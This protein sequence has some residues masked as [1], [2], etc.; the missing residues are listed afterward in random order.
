MSTYYTIRTEVKMHDGWHCVDPLILCFKRD[1]S[2]PEYRLSTTYWSGSRSY[3]GSTADKLEEMSVACKYDELSAELKKLYDSWK[4]ETENK[5]EYIM[6]NTYVVPLARIRKAVDS[7]GGKTNHGIVH[8]DAIVAFETGELEDIYNTLDPREYT[9]LDPEA[10]KLYQYYE[11]DDAM[12]WGPHLRTI[13][14]KAVRRIN[15]FANENWIEEELE[16]RILMF[17]S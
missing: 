14:E 10:K 12:H 11:W 16:A 2:E 3:F 8:K 6:R 1:N 5:E 4:F 9:E 13:L 15:E 7:L 17:V